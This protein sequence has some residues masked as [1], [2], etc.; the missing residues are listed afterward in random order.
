MDPRLHLLGIRHHGPG[1]AALVVAALDRLDPAAVL[2]EG[3]PE[4]S[5]LVPH[6]A[7]LKPPVAMLFYAVDNPK[8]AIFAPF[9]EFSPE[10]Q[11]LHWAAARARPVVFI[12]WPAALS[13]AFVPDPDAPARRGDSL[14]R[15]A[16]MAGHRDGEAF[17]NGLVEESGGL[18]EPL[19]TFQAIGEAMAEVRAQAESEGDA[20]E[21]RDLLR[22]AHMR[23]AIRQALKDHAGPLAA[24]VGAWHVPA[25]T[26][27]VPQAED[28]AVL[29]DLP[30]VKVAATWAPWTDSRLALASGYGAGVVSPGW[31]RHLWRAHT[32][33]RQDAATFAAVWQARTA[34]LLRAEGMPASLA[35][36]IEAARLTLALCQIRDL[37][38]PGLAEMREAALAALCHGEATPLRL[39]E[40]RL[41]IGE[42]VGEIAEDVP[43]MPLARD[44][45]LWQRRTR[46][47]P[48]D[49]E[50]EIRL[51]LRSE[52]G[53]MKSTLL[54]RLTILNLPWG[55]LLDADGGRGTFRE[56]WQLSWRPEH[57]V[58]LAEALVYGVTIEDAAGNLIRDK[59]RRAPTI[60]ACAGFVRAAL[61]AD[62]PEAATQAIAELQALAVNASDLTDLMRTVAPL[63]SVL[64][65][66]TARKLPEEAL[67]ALI[68]ALA[69]EVHAGIRIGSRHLDADVASARVAA[70]RGFDEALGL[71]KDEALTQ[72]WRRQLQ[73]IAGDDLA[74]P[75]VAGFA[76]RRL[77]DLGTLGE[78]EVAQAFARRMTG[79]PVE[80]GGFLDAFLA[81][82][83]E[84]LLQETSL[85]GLVDVWLGSLDAEGFMEVLPLL[86]RAFAGFDGPARKRLVSLVAKRR[87]QPAGTPAASGI[88]ADDDPGEAAFAVA[89]PLL[90]TILGLEEPA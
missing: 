90:R 18:G 81:G 57:A 34:A 55:R 35:S 44:L 78:A 56:V 9:A 25:L 10:W 31:Y 46:L 65:Y 87:F 52:A 89:L 12:D 16:E 29:R 48:E 23:L 83:A 70:M 7:G 54:H 73:L 86:R 28:R 60:D 19:A 62:L 8:A 58:A 66:G 6:L 37:A 14:D 68:T 51:D 30:K 33:D 53:L 67:R 63:A 42:S 59:A 39:V 82:G 4:G 61:V 21:R 88:S 13:L 74:S 36:A 5:V 26:A 17:W 15:L 41:Y 49:L 40:R 85:V 76:L 43:Q 79:P 32:S 1:S 27:R 77:A 71:L 11:A 84:L 80:A 69:V 3:A 24:I 47:K 38:M 22:E 50:S 75:A 2:I 72:D 64:R 45:A 20:T